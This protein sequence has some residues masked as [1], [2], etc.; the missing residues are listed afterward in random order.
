MGNMCEA[1]FDRFGADSRDSKLYKVPIQRKSMGSFG[2]TPN[3]ARQGY[4]PKSIYE[5]MITYP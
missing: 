5:D 1:E 4:T 3:P 2:S